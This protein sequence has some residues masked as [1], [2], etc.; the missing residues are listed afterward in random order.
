M[1]KRNAARQGPRGR[2]QNRC[3]VP[4]R[5]GNLVHEERNLPPSLAGS[6]AWDG[7]FNGRDLTAGVYVYV[8]KVTYID[9]QDEIR[10]GD[11]TLFR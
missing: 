7:R 3:S 5:W 4:D 8:V 2:S 11:V 9:N 6:G 1:Y 10:K